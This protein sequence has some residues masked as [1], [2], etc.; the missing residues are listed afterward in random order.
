MKIVPRSAMLLGAAGLLPFLW[1]VLTT[2]SPE[3]AEFTR[4]TVGPRFLGTY[5][6]IS[7][8]TVILAFMSGV[9]WGFATKTEGKAAAAAYALSTLPALWAFFVFGPGAQVAAQNLIIG[10]IGLLILDWG[11]QRQGLAPDWWLSL[12]IPLTA[13]VIACLLVA[14]L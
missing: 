13:G 5:L 9:L 1:G 11:F 14:A 4:T 8:G 10:Y 12:R 3:M 7:Y 6:I 2:L